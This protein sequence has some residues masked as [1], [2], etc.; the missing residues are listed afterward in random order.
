MNEEIMLQHQEV[1]RRFLQNAVIVDD[2]AYM[3]SVW[4]RERSS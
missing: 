1:A 3:E 2:E 4:K